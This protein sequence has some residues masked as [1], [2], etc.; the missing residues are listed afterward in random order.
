MGSFWFM[1]IVAWVKNVWKILF[2][3][4]I[5]IHYHGFDVLDRQNSRHRRVTFIT[6]PKHRKE[7][8]V[9]EEKANHGSEFLDQS[10]K[11]LTL[12]PSV[13]RQKRWGRQTAEFATFFRTSREGQLRA[14]KMSMTIPSMTCNCFRKKITWQW[15]SKELQNFQRQQSYF[16]WSPLP[17]FIFWWFSGF[18]QPASKL[19]K[20]DQCPHRSLPAC[21]VSARPASGPKQSA[22]VPTVFPTAIVEYPSQEWQVIGGYF[23]LFQKYSST[24]TIPHTIGWKMKR[25]MKPLTRWA[26]NNHDVFPRVQNG[27]PIPSKRGLTSQSS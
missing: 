5:W 6:K 22:S 14:R 26:V 4:L 20:H 7:N 13:Q 11:N 18:W 17:R 15:S 3:C 25:E 21:G 27:L 19:S 8:R 2:T 10:M 23:N 9:N 12:T 16:S 1:H 24:T